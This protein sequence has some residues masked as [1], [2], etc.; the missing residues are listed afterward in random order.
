MAT[1]PSILRPR[2]RLIVHDLLRH[3]SH[4]DFA[5]DVRR[6]L[7]AE[8]KH[9]FPKYLYDDLG[10]KLFEAIC[11]LDEYYLTRAEGQILATHADEIIESIPGDK[12]LI[13]MGSGSASKT[14]AIIEAL[15]RNQEQLKFIPVDIS[16]SA[17]EN[18]SRAL[19]R[20]YETLSIEGYAADYFDAL[21]ALGAT[22]RGR[23]LVLFLG[24]NIG[25]FEQEEALTFLRAI[26]SVL[27]DG[28][29]LLLG[30]D[31][32]KDSATLE[33]AYNDKLG[34][35]QSFIV[36]EL[37]RINRELGANFDLSQFKLRSKYDSEA[38]RVEVHLESLSP[39]SITIADLNLQVTLK[40]GEH[41]HVEK[42]HKYDMDQLSVLAAAS[43]FRRARTWC[44]DRRFFSSSLFLAIQ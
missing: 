42:A 4:T 36:N 32:K 11:Y 28:D 22:S 9:L 12:T 21:V 25:N 35:T 15:L 24:S 27:R 33:A 41:I 43:G 13:E 40:V 23:T 34:V 16:A 44:D 3:N 14:R 17:L 2:E 8:P 26:R 38:G 19:L 10:S 20:S 39:Q 29:G 30:A 5:E 6:G 37:A 1:L 18:S 7:S 31:L